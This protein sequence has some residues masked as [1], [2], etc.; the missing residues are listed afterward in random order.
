MERDTTEKDR[1]DMHALVTHHK[2]RGEGR[3]AGA[4][5]I[6]FFYSLMLLGP[7]SPFILLALIYWRCYISF[8]AVFAILVWPF[9]LEVEPSTRV[10]RLLMLMAG[11]FKDGITQWF[12]R[13][14]LESYKENP[15]AGSLWCY[16]PHG[17]GFGFGFVVNGA[18]R[19]KAD[20]DPGRYLTEE[21]ASIAPKERLRQISGVMAPIFF[22]IPLMRHLLLLGGPGAPATKKEMKRLFDLR[23]DFGILPGG[24]EEV[25]AYRSGRDRVYIRRRAGFIKYALQA[26]YRLF[27]AYTFGESDLYYSYPFGEGAQMWMLH[28]FGCILPVFWGKFLLLPFLPRDDVAIHTVV[29]APLQLPRITHPTKADVEHWHDR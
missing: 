29:G 11:W 12:A 18:M 8:L 23:S 16:H 14:V 7:L 26:G 2:Y 5:S 19:Y 1:S 9:V 10:A 24:S 4:V 6:I 28:H 22:K 20:G 27:I 3:L 25:L 17:T 13:G 15:T 21:M